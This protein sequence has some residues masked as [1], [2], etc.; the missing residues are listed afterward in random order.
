VEGSASGAFVAVILAPVTEGA[1]FDA[2]G[3]AFVWSAAPEVT[4]P[5]G[6]FRNCWKR[7]QAESATPR[8]TTYCP[9]VGMV[10]SDRGDH[11]LVLSSYDLAP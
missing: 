8:I 7:T 4:V 3:I 5:A 10:R 1:T 6:T 2:G 11:A 9:G